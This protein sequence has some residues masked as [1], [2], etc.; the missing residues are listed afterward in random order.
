MAHPFKPSPFRP[1]PI[2]RRDL[3]RTVAGG[4]A[5]VGLGPILVSCASTTRTSSTS[6]GTAIDQL[7]EPQAEILRYASFAPSGHNAQPWQVTVEGPDRWILSLDPQRLLPEIDPENREAMLSLGHFIENLALAAGSKGFETDVEVLAEGGQD[8]EVAR[9]HL[10]SGA[11]VDYPLR[12][13]SRRRTLRSGFSPETLTRSDLDD[14]L[15][16]FAGAGTYFPR[17]SREANWL[18]EAAVEAMRE[19][20]WRDPAQQ[21][22]SNWVH[23]DRSRAESRRDGLTPE[24]M[25]VS[26]FGRQYMYLFMDE[27]SVMK[28]SF[29]E[30]GIET[31]EQQAGEGGGWLVVTSPD[32][33]PTSLLKTGRRTQQMWLQCRDRKIAVHPMSQVLEEQPWRQKIAN[34]IGLDQEPQYLLRVGYVSDYPEPVSMR[35]PVDDFTKLS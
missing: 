9:I 16:P 30:R 21:E 14:L 17:G 25:E 5:L 22:L 4:A 11:P 33:S 15:A 29:R 8:R 3:L 19:Q 10:T 31:A 18:Q 6:S 34:A 24:T 20:T 32:H 2:P 12:R 1:D 23:L 28:E 27:D 13:L 7:G 26:W 35:R